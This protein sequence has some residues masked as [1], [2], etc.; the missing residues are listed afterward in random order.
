MPRD[1]LARGSEV[2]LANPAGHRVL[3]LPVYNDGQ[4]HLAIFRRQGSEMSLQID[5]SAARGDD[6][7][8]ARLPLSSLD[9]TFGARKRGSAPFDGYHRRVAR[10]QWRS[11]QCREPGVVLGIRHALQQS[12]TSSQRGRI[13]LCPRTCR[14]LSWPLATE[15]WPMIPI[16]NR[17]R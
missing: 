2:A 1:R 11:G 13:Q 7:T 5:D 3:G 16:G 4:T 8:P 17:I 14:C 9:M 6:A 12:G 15:C 10:L